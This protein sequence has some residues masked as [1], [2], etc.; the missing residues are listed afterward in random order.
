MNLAIQVF[1][2]CIESSFPVAT[3]MVTS[4]LVSRNRKTVRGFK[5]PKKDFQNNFLGPSGRTTKI[6]RRGNVAVYLFVSC[7]PAGAVGGI[8]ALANV[9]GKECVQLYNLLLQN[10]LEAARK[11]QLSLIAPNQAVSC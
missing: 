10:D 7:L 6:K 1:C 2:K 3:K 11:L 5:L 4:W 8:C 9:L